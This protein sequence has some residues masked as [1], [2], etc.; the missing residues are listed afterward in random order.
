MAMLTAARSDIIRRQPTLS[1]Q[2]SLLNTEPHVLS[3]GS[4]IHPEANQTAE[5]TTASATTERVRDLQTI[6]WMMPAGAACG[7]AP[8]G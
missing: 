8:S 5:P 1:H 7:P 3:G 6:P 4:A 2:R